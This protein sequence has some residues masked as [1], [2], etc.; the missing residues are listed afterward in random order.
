MVLRLCD[1]DLLFLIS[2][3]QKALPLIELIEHGAIP[4]TPTLTYLSNFS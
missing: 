3:G 2:F 4:I 1:V